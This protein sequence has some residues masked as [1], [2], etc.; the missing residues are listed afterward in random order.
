M[1][2]PLGKPVSDHVPCLV[3]IQTSI[4]CSKIFRFEFI[5]LVQ[6]VWNRPVRSLN[7]AIVLCR[8]FKALRH[9]LKLW[10]KNLSRLSVAI[11]NCNEILA[12]IDELEN[13]RP[14]SIPETN[15]R[16]ILKKHLL[17]LLNYQNQY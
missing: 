6:E 17:H 16:T 13:N 10:I 12:Q 8:K 7:A 14:L 3:S 9:A 15:F 1:V 2:K 4:L 5:D 11:A